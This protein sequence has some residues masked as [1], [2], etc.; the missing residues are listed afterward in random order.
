V[1]LHAF[2]LLQLQQTLRFAGSNLT[3]AEFMTP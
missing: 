1:F 2:L 3:H